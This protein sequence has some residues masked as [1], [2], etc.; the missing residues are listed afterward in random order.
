VP[1]LHVGALGTLGVIVAAH[2]R[3]HPVPAAEQTWL[4][5]FPGAE[6]ALDAA[7]RVLDAALTPS[8]VELLGAAA[9]AALAP[10]IGAGAGLAVTVGSVPAAVRAQ[11]ERVHDACRLSDGQAVPLGEADVWWRAVGDASWPDGPADLAL[12]IGSRPTDVV[13]ALRAL[14]AACGPGARIRATAEVASG[15]LHAVIQG[16]PA[17]TGWL[18][19]LRDSLARLDAVAVVEHAPPGCKAALDVWG[20]V[21]PALGLMRALKVELD[22]RGVLNPGRF[23]GGI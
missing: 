3:L 1:K 18:A 11:G 15:V 14:E 12:R 22:P 4:F 9:L 8:R 10:G 21:G 17:A 23:V 2:L 19:P 16:A 13:K 6:A 5:G 20:D 7:L